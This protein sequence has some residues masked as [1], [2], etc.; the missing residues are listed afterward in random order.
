M[1]ENLLP[2]LYVCID[3]A[4][5]RAAFALGIFFEFYT[6]PIPFKKIHSKPQQIPRQKNGPMQNP[7]NLF[8]SAMNKVANFFSFSSKRIKKN[9]T[10]QK[11]NKFIVS[12]KFMW[13]QFTLFASFFWKILFI[14]FSRYFFFWMGIVAGC[15]WCI[16]VF[17]FGFCNKCPLYGFVDDW[18]FFSPNGKL[19][20]ETPP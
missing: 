2:M 17:R 16:G 13:K 20:V 18:S 15:Q 8:R 12:E 3:R 10:K 6:P 5:W 9:L 1:L 4:D 7:I 11:A 19:L 14:S